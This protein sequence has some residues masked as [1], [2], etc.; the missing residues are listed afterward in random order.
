[1]KRWVVR[2]PVSRGQL[3][4]FASTTVVADR[5]E[6]SEGVAAFYVE[7]PDPRTV[8]GRHTFPDYLELIRA[9]GVGQWRDIEPLASPPE[10]TTD[11]EAG[12][13]R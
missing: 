10:E 6:L 8:R 9:F 13:I 3:V 4:E 7:R 2:Y 5:I 12:V 11:P 1:M